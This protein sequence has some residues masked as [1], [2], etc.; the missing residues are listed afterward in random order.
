MSDSVLIGTR[1]SKL[2]LVQ[3]ERVRSALRSKYAGLE[4]E[5]LVIK[6]KGDKILDSPLSQIGGKGLFIRE[7]EEGFL[8]EE[9][10][11][12]DNLWTIGRRFSFWKV[13]PRPIR[14]RQYEPFWSNASIC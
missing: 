5:I 8:Q 9:S 4:A 6:T 11:S 14:D 12:N 7:I 1:G 3:A 2:A 10:N 13:F